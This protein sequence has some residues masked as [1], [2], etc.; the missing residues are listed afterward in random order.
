[1]T[2]LLVAPCIYKAAK[3]AVENWHYSK[4]MPSAKCTYFGVWENN[5]F[6][7]VIVFGQGANKNLVKPYNLTMFE[8]CELCRIAL[9]E[10]ASPVTQILSKSIKELK[11]H[12][13][14]LRLIVSFADSRQ[15][16]LGIIYQASNWFYT[17][18]IKGSP[19]YFYNGQWIHQRTLFGHMSLKDYKGIKR[20]SGFRLRY[21]MPLDKKMR[22][23]IEPLAK[24]YPKDLQELSNA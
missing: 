3:Y 8:G 21:L 17:G 11:K 4:R 6:I 7:G 12:S 5:A 9:K 15:N 19:E 23:Q 18:Y 20:S 1:M 16:H 22:K 14:G 13:P 24:P 2:E 10:H